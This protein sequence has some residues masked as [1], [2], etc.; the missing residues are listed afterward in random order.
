MKHPLKGGLKLRD[1]KKVGFQ[2]VMDMLTSPSAKIRLLSYRSLQAFML[3]I[4]VK[5]EDSE[6]DELIGTSFSKPVTSYVMK[7][8]I[9]ANEP[10]L[11]LK[12]RFLGILEKEQHKDGIEKQTDT[13]SYFFQEAKLQQI[14][15]KRSI[16]NGCPAICPPIANF[17][18]FHNSEAKTFINYLLFNESKPNTDIKSGFEYLLNFL[19]SC[20]GSTCGI[21]VLVMPM[22]QNS[23]TLGELISKSESLVSLD[24]GSFITNQQIAEALACVSSR[25]LWMVVG[26]HMMHYDLHSKNA[27]VSFS[28]QGKVNGCK[29]IDFGKAS[30]LESMVSDRHLLNHEKTEIKKKCQYFEKLIL[31]PTKSDTEK[32][33]R[34]IE[35][36]N[37]VKNLDI[38][39][40]MKMFKVDN[41]QINLIYKMFLEMPT[42]QLMAYDNL[43]TLLSTHQD[44]IISK[45]VELLEKNGQLVNLDH[46][47]NSFYVPF[48]LTNTTR[49][50]TSPMM[51]PI[52]KKLRYTPQKEVPTLLDRWN[53][54]Y[55]GKRNSNKRKKAKRCRKTLRR[56]KY[57]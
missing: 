19:S 9:L 55:G 14:L 36:M 8:A 5:Q 24:D 39:N 35:V 18:L 48:S 11:V 16:Q 49:Q 28:P 15:W 51:S 43:K 57:I 17:A 52:K 12:E 7:I 21:G 41:P 30:D 47:L 26:L 38:A 42:I 40:N 32:K 34:I 4:D 6:Y 53:F 20:H 37:F 3:S 56:K 33:T 46:P 22:I 23:M 44:G 1:P 31:L 54:Q 27:M 13:P 50:H 45:T 29:L 10:P 2:P 25:L